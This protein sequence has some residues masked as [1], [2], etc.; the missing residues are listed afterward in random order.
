MNRPVAIYSVPSTELGIIFRSLIIN[1]IGLT[2]QFNIKSVLLSSCEVSPD[3]NI[4]NK[5]EN[6]LLEFPA[7][8]NEPLLVLPTDGS[9]TVDFNWVHD[10]LNEQIKHGF[11][12]SGSNELTHDLVGWLT[13]NSP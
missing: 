1:Q 12:V 8:E 5:Y 9:Y 10:K 3:G 13:E 6:V 2:D 7:Y 4:F 11:Q